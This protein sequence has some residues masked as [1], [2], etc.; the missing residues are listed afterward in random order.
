MTAK[1]LDDMAQDILNIKASMLEEK[2]KIVEV[3]EKL[4]LVNHL[5]ADS[6]AIKK[7]IQSASEK[8]LI[9]IQKIEEISN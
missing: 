4:E 5:L 9:R 6:E 7:T 8:I 2:E 3:S 1:N